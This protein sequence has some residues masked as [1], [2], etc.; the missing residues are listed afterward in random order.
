[1]TDDTTLQGKWVPLKAE[2]SGENAPPEMLARMELAFT[3]GH[4]AVQFGGENAEAGDYTLMATGDQKSL[5]MH[6]STGLHSG[7]TLPCIYQLA[8]DRLRICYGLDGS[9][10][11]AFAAAAGTP[12]YLVSYRRKSS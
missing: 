10:P 11:P 8:G 6:A 1:M 2:L 12:H 7:R 9:L 3:H 5:T 4:Y